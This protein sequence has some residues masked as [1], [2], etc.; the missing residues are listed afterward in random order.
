VRARSTATTWS[1]NQTT[2]AIDKE[3]TTTVAAEN[4]YLNGRYDRNITEKL[5]W[6]AGAGW[7]RNLPAG[8][9]SKY[10]EAGGLGNIWSDT[11]TVKFRTDYSVT[12]SQEKDVVEP[13]DFNGNFLGARFSWVYLH[14]FGANTTY[15]NDFTVDENLDKT[16]DYRGDMTNWVAVTMSQRLALKVSLQ[17]LYRHEPSFTEAP[18]PGN[19][20]A[21]NP[22]LVQLDSLD[23][24]FMAS[25]VMKF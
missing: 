1:V 21:A 10:W 12:Y 7:E 5:F 13:P 24:I 6:Y 20:S 25:L 19:V 4:Y 22:D 23:S 9:E 16:T 15:G 17:W 18:D 14:K 8:I 3:S 11:E 2:G